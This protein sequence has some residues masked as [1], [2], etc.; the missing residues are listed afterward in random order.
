MTWQQRHVA[1][2]R[3]VFTSE[4]PWTPISESVCVLPESTLPIRVGR[5]LRTASQ[6]I[7]VEAAWAKPP[8]QRR[9]FSMV[10]R[11]N[12]SVIPSMQSAALPAKDDQ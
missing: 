8:G 2:Q 12:T 9:R 1:L 7:L 4:A 10:D 6:I 3:K 5:W 11:L